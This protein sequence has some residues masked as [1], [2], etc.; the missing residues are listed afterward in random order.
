MRAANNKTSFLSKVFSDV[1]LSTDSSE[2]SVR[3]PFCGKAGKSKM[4]IIIETD[5]YHCWVCDEKG[6]GLGKLIKKVAP[7]KLQE[8]NEQ[9]RST[10]SPAQKIEEQI[11]DISLPEDFALLAGN[12]FLDPDGRQILKYATSRGFTKSKLWK[13]RVGYSKENQ[14]RRR[15]ILPSFD[16]DGEL[17]FIT[18]RAIDKANT[19][20]YKNESVSRNTVVYNE[21][22][23]DFSRGLVLV[24][25]PL[26]LIKVPYNATCLLGSSLNTESRLFHQIAKNQTPVILL[27]DPDV[28]KK[29]FRI[30]DLLSDFSVDVKVNFPP[31]GKDIN[32]LRE[33]E[34]EHL[35]KT[36][37]QY[38]YACKMKIKL[39]A[40]K[41]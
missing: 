41:I 30:A 15:L 12:D 25:G 19:F 10:K 2:I 16:E 27:L 24:E 3:C 18:G 8:Y 33:D 35:I 6:R 22:D 23:V 39:G 28:K 32:D 38:T 40:I 26:D 13:F 9:Y 31:E 17:N 36:A 20:R 11:P 14:W 37:Q 4:C 7:Q 29:V 21:I 1:R 34:V 5:V